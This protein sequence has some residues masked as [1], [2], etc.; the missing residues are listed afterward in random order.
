MLSLD[1]ASGIY[2]IMA[3]IVYLV[4]RRH[5]IS[6]LLPL[7]PSAWALGRGACVLRVLALE[8]IEQRRPDGRVSLRV[9]TH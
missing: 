4:S 7:N 8:D 2:R 9:I 1:L 5:G 3:S 6:A